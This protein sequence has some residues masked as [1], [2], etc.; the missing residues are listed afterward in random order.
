MERYD[1][2]RG[3]A[4]RPA[5]VYYSMVPIFIVVYYPSHYWTTHRQSV[6]RRPFGLVPPVAAARGS[7]LDRTPS[8]RRLALAYVSIESAELVDALGD[9]GSDV[10][11]ELVGSSRAAHGVE[12]RLPLVDLAG[13][14]VE[15]ALHARNLRLERSS[16]LGFE[17]VAR[18]A[19]FSSGS[20]PLNSRRRWNR[21]LPASPMRRR[22]GAG[23]PS[24]GARAF[25]RSMTAR[26]R[27]EGRTPS[28]RRTRAPPPRRP[29]GRGGP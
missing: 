5:I 26:G 3:A 19:G 1:A 12:E 8:R 7:S 10:C 22:V 24:T 18:R 21:S 20:V 29:W 14:R 6:F 25:S 17:T 28:R 9:F 4:T 13:E 11:L 2:W 16:W 23:G 15:H 27:T